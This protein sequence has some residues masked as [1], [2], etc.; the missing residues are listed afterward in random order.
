MSAAFQRRLMLDELDKARRKEV[1][2]VAKQAYL[3][4]L[5]PT[6]A[7]AEI[8]SLKRHELRQIER[9]GGFRGN[10][11]KRHTMTRDLP[12]LRNTLAVEE[13]LDAA[14]DQVDHPIRSRLRR[15]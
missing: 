14:K 8:R 4:G 11:A 3:S 2:A 5:E 9:A 1:I 10:K 7:P 12:K 15:R 6:A 13:V